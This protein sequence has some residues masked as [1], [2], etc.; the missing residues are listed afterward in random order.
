MKDMWH[1]L[2]LCLVGEEIPLCAI[3]FLWL[4]TLVAILR[5]ALSPGAKPGR[6]PAGD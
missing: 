2:S 4:D 3:F 1:W 5:S 6:K